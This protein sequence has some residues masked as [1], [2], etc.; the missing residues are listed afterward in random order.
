MIKSKLLNFKAVQRTF[1][2]L[3]NLIKEARN[4][5]VDKIVLVSTEVLRK[6]KNKKEFL[7][8]FKTKFNLAIKI[9]SR[10]EEAEFGALA[11]L[12][13]YSIK[14]HPLIVIDIG[15][16]SAEVSRL[17][18]RNKNFKSLPLFI[19]IK[20]NK[21]NFLKEKAD[22][23]G[24]G[25]TIVALACI[26][27]KLKKID[28]KKIEGFSINLADLKKLNQEFLKLSYKKREKISGLEPQR[29]DIILAGGMI[30]EEFMRRFSFKNCKV[31]SV[32]LLFGL[33]KV[34]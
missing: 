3:T 2:A 30:L 14:S 29:A 5:K 24:I 1:K 32:N 26:F 16:G 4:D 10:K 33:L 18:G 7:R 22:L 31:S 23:V 12:E 21:I 15:G 25:G 20:L 13:K 6:A 11:V 19:N 9:L 28:L 17:F 8:L 34:I 27:L